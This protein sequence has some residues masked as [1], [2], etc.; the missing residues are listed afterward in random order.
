MTHSDTNS[1]TTSINPVPIA[2]VI[3]S[4][5]SRNLPVIAPPSATPLQVL[6]LAEAAAE[7]ARLANE[8]ED[9]TILAAIR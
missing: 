1:I 6:S 3:D 2:I 9:K 7:I 8:A 5:T 4:V